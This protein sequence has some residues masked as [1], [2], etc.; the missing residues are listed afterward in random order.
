MKIKENKDIVEINKNEENSRVDTKV[1]Y[2]KEN[3]CNYNIIM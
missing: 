2:E 1:N 3:F